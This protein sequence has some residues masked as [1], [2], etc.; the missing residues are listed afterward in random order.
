MYAPAYRVLVAQHL[1]QGASADDKSYSSKAMAAY[2]NSPI[3]YAF[4]CMEMGKGS[5]LKKP[6][7]RS[8]RQMLDHPL[9]SPAMQAMFTTL[10]VR[11]LFCCTYDMESRVIV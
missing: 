7:L 5:V 1:L 4:N 2:M 3:L 9:G 10:Y 11:I 6:A 8:I